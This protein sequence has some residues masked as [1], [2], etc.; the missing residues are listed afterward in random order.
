MAV[1]AL[2]S[3]YLA[4]AGADL[5]TH[6]KQVELTVDAAELDSTDFASAGWEDRIGGLK[7]ATLSFTVN[8]DE[9][10]SSI[11]SILWGHFN[12]G[13]A[14]TFEVRATSAAV[15]TSNPKFT[16]SVLPVGWTAGGSVGDLAE[17]SLTWPVT[18]AVTRATA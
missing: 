15:G 9:A 8:D 16:G 10:V 13:T 17:K 12:T 5:S 6:V 1:F 7:S 14:V 4:L 2:T 3:T 11:S 18:G